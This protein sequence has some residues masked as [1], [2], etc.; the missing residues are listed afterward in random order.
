MPRRQSRTDAGLGQTPK[1][2][3]H[4]SRTNHVAAATWFVREFIG[5]LGRGPHRSRQNLWRPPHRLSGTFRSSHDSTLSRARQNLWRPPQ[6]LS[7]MR[8]HGGDALPG[9]PHDKKSG[10]RHYFCPGVYRRTRTGATWEPTKLVAAATPFVRDVRL[11]SRKYFVPCTTKRVAA[12]TWFVRLASTRRRRPLWD[13]ARQKKWRP[14]HRLSGTFRPSHESTLSHAARTM[15]ASLSP[16]AATGF[17]RNAST[18]RRSRL[19]T[20]HD[21]KSGGRH[22]FCPGVYRGTR[23]GATRGPTKLVAAATFFV[24]HDG[25]RRNLGEMQAKTELFLHIL[26]EFFDGVFDRPWHSGYR[27]FEAWGYADAFDRQVLRLQERAILEA[28]EAH[29]SKDRTYRLTALGRVAAQ[30][31]TD[32]RSRWSRRWDGQWRLVA[33]DIPEERHA[34]REKWRRELRRLKFGCLQGS[35]WVSPDPVD[36]LRAAFAGAVVRTQ[37]LIF[38]EGR[39]AAGESDADI[40]RAAWDFEPINRLY[41]EHRRILDALP[42]PKRRSPKCA[43]DSRRGRNANSSR[44]RKSSPAIPSCRTPCF[45]P[46]IP[47]APRWTRGKRPCAAPAP[48]RANWLRT[49]SQ[50]L[51]AATDCVAVRVFRRRRTGMTG[52]AV[53]CGCHSEWQRRPAADCQREQSRDGCATLALAQC[54]SGSIAGVW[55]RTKKVAAATRFVGHG[56]AGCGAVRRDV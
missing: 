50:E 25:V 21:K 22:F 23:T 16:A 53:S 28:A 13:H 29:E 38:I 15:S 8:R 42:N 3:P 12:A 2:T 33:F 54:H 37:R 40:V 49:E 36:E 56:P 18:P 46:T 35:V 45:R 9:T 39:P 14:P 41:A 43:R 17:V 5:G 32:P 30:G 4:P 27:P 7:G 6:G 47:V 1:K 31:G 55:N 24:V 44:G 20:P 52:M 51:A 48:S 26:G 11:K 10:G 34:V 19:W